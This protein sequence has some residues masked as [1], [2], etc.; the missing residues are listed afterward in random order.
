MPV[1]APLDSRIC[2]FALLEKIT[3]SITLIMGIGTSAQTKLAIA[4]PDVFGVTGMGGGVG[5]GKAG[6]V[7]VM[8]NQPLA[9][10]HCSVKLKAAKSSR[11]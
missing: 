3:A 8:T 7:S 4:R 9:K 1:S 11:Y 2:C 6:G 5:D 10:A